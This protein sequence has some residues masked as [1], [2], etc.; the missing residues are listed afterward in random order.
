MVIYSLSQN[1]VVM[2]H[3]FV[4]QK[5]LWAVQDI[6]WHIVL[7]SKL[8]KVDKMGIIMESWVPSVREHDVSLHTT[9]AT[10]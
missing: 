2:P 6:V 4:N 7:V 5:V 9:W 8:I 10:I 3:G 1:K